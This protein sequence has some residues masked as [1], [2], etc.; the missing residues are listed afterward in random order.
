MG[1]DVES[2]PRRRRQPS[3]AD[4]HS[5]A[6][7]RFQGLCCT[8]EE[9]TGL[10]TQSLEN[11]ETICQACTRLSS[12]CEDFKGVLGDDYNTPAPQGAPALQMHAKKQQKDEAEMELQGKTKEAEMDKAEKKTIVEDD[13][14]EDIHGKYLHFLN[15]LLRSGSSLQAAAGIETDFHV[16]VTKPHDSTTILDGAL[17]ISCQSKEAR[18]KARVCPL[19]KFGQIAEYLRDDNMVGICI[20]LHY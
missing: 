10:R 19:N 7:Q 15:A 1:G 8:V 11:I 17:R 2:P 18:M 3:Q 5:R 4:R 9:V 12:T 16:F 20:I 14:S 13:N 6:A